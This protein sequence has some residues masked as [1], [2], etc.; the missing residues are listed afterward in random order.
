[1][2][3]TFET[4]ATFDPDL[5]AGLIQAGKQAL[6]Q[7]EQKRGVGADMQLRLVFRIKSVVFVWL[8]YLRAHAIANRSRKLCLLWE[9]L[10]S[11]CYFLDK[12]CFLLTCAGQSY[13]TLTFLSSKSIP[14]SINYVSFLSFGEV[15]WKNHQFIHFQAFILCSHLIGNVGHVFCSY[16]ATPYFTLL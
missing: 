4:L 6:I 15:Q 11:S 5:L 10:R 7:L 9:I 14:T 13:F 16:S 2:F 1:M 3:K 8:R 12:K